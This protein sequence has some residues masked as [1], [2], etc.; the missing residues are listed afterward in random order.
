MV[1]TP[2]LGSRP[3]S[4]GR[5]QSWITGV[6]KV[7]INP[8]TPQRRASRRHRGLR[9]EGETGQTG[10]PASGTPPPHSP[11]A[12]NERRALPLRPQPR[13][14]PEPRYSHRAVCAA[15]VVPRLCGYT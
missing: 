8:R 3:G 5:Q 13:L 4:F 6:D 10:T 15:G 14:G 9:P 7:A 11:I 2:A 1:E 12:I